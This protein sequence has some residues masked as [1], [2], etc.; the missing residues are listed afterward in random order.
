MAGDRFREDNQSI[1][2]LAANLSLP[3]LPLRYIITRA[4]IA[5]SSDRDSIDLDH[6]PHQTVTSLDIPIQY[7]YM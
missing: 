7:Q 4:Y 6:T 2:S 1:E 5:P 3:R